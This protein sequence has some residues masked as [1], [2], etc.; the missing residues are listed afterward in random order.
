MS[1]ES[2]PRH[3]KRIHALERA[4]KLDR[5]IGLPEFNGMRRRVRKSFK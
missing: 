4:E 2:W 5:L 3:Q 1:M